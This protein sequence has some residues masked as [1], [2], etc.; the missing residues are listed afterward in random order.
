MA[1]RILFQQALFT[2]EKQIKQLDYYQHYLI[3]FK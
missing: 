2:F 1:R 3:M